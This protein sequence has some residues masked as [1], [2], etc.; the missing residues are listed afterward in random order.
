MELIYLDCDNYTYRWKFELL[1]KKAQ[2]IIQSVLFYRFHTIIQ[3][4]N[5]P[6]IRKDNMVEKVLL[7]F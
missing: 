7:N 5:K 3:L 2:S 6:T 4:Q 1:T